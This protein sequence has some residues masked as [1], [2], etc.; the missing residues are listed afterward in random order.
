MAEDKKFL[1]ALKTKFDQDPNETSTKYYGFGGWEQSPRK[2]EFNEYAEKV[3][4][5]RGG[6]P[7][8]NPDI[9]VP[10]GQ[11]QLMSYKISGTDTY[12][13]GDDLHF[14]NNSAIQQLS[15]DIKR[16]IIVG[17]DTAHAVLERRLGVE[18]TPETINEYMETINHA[19][20]GGA[21]VQ[22]HMV[23]VHPGLVGDCYAKI[24]TGDDTLAD[25]LDSR[26]IIDINKEFPEEQA[27]MLKKYVGSKTYQVS[28]LPTS[29][30]RTCDGGTTSRWSAMQIGMSF[31][32]AYKLCAGEAAISEFAYAA[33]H[34]DVIEMG[35]FLPARRARGPN[36]PGGISFGILADMV[37]TSRASE[38]P[39]EVTLEV[40]AA[41]AAIYDQIWLGSYMSGGVG[42]TQYATAAYTD[43]ILDDFVYYGMEY[44]QDK[45]GICGAKADDA[46]V[47]DISTEVTLYAMEQYE[48]PT[49]LEDHFGG[50]QRACVAA[51]AAG[52]STA[53][54]TGNSNAGINGWY[55][56][57]ILH[58]EVHSRLGFYGYDLQD[59][60]GASNS[61]S[62]R[63]DEGLIHELRGPNYPNYAMNVGHQPEY[64][65]IAQAPHAAR[66]D[67]FCVNPLIKIAFADKNLAFDFE[68]PRKSIAKGALREFVPSGERDL[69]T[70]AK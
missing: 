36:E 57:Q 15:D 44:V 33:K 32:S 13:E 34:A 43:D 22:E 18:V 45:F 30:V 63:S 35:N 65:G 6:I 29:V 14:V 10:L 1:K 68:S 53:F 27:E 55:L 3:A 31:I 70:P 50:S 62:I 41:A 8:Y 12:V 24:F 61:L 16:T 42:F 47:K 11:R 21:V 2:K 51:A 59:Q 23:E 69:I 28:R 19:L 7:G 25:E 40:I 26:F 64:A 66:G 17:M 52:V 4:A 20:P 58:K 5:E 46:V 49:L 38:D 56:S 60:C 67:A 48:I 54:A 39:A 37:Q 9:G